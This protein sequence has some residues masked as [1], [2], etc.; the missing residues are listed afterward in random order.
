MRRLLA[1]VLLVA[2]GGACEGFR[3][4]V[5]LDGGT[6][7]SALGDVDLAGADLTGL[8]LTGLVPPDLAGRG[9]TDGGAQ[10][11]CGQL[12]GL[13]CLPRGTR[14][15]EVPT[16]AS[17][18]AAL[19]AAQTGDT[20]QVRGVT[21]GGNLTLPGFVTLRGC[22]GAG[23][24]ATVRFNGGA[25]A[26]EGFSS[27]TG[28]IV[29]NATGS[30]FVRDNI[31]RAPA[32]AGTPGVSARS[33]DGLVSADVTMRVE[34]N[35]FTDRDVGVEAATRYD[36]M[37]HTVTLTVI[38][39]AFRSV[40]AP[41][42]ASEAGLVG[43]IALRVEHNTFVGFD[44]AVRLT[45][46]TYMTPAVVSNVFSNGT[47]A[48]AGNSVFTT[49]DEIAWMVTTI[50]GGGSPLAGTF[51]TRDPLLTNPMNDDFHPMSGSPALGRVG[52]PAGVPDVDLYHCP[53][54]SLRALGAAEAL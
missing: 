7:A 32:T 18:S 17:I 2:L 38:N 37:T 3:P 1:A 4:I 21:I 43:K 40:T 22:E 27:I 10:S 23:L 8:D 45:D 47:N 51:D 48:I 6:D 54:P 16:E 20:I 9:A 12:A 34:R 31:F 5:D 39:N 11:P 52:T 53:R 14:V 36:T 35:L 42:T 41:V 33:I 15:L 24:A 28:G 30:Y 44:A 50:V 46:V 13:P 26:V 29:A 19:T 49:G 25:G